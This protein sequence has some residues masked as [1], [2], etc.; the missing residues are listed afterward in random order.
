MTSPAFLVKQN[1]FVQELRSSYSLVL[2]IP[3]ENSLD[4]KARSLELKVS[5]VDAR[6]NE[7]HFK[8]V[9]ETVGSRASRDGARVFVGTASGA[10][11]DVFELTSTLS[12]RKIRE[13]VSFKAKDKSQSQPFSFAKVEI[14][15]A[16]GTPLWSNGIKIEAEKPVSSSGKNERNKPVS[17]NASKKPD[18]QKTVP[19]QVEETTRHQKVRKEEQPSEKRDV[20]K[21]AAEKSK[22]AKKPE[23]KKEVPASS[24][25]ST[26]AAKK[27]VPKQV[28]EQ[29]LDRS[30]SY[31]KMT[32]AEMLQELRTKPAELLAERK[33]GHQGF[34]VFTSGQALSAED[35]KRLMAF[36]TLCRKLGEYEVFN[37]LAGNNLNYLDVFNEV[38]VNGK[39]DDATQQAV[40]LL[41]NLLVKYLESTGVRNG[42]EIGTLGGKKV[43]LRTERLANGKVGAQ[44]ITA[45]FRFMSEQEKARELQAKPEAKE[46]ASD[47]AKEIEAI[48]KMPLNAR[49]SA[50]LFS[51]A[52]PVRPP[53]Q[54][55]EAPVQNDIDRFNGHDLMTQ[56]DI[57]AHSEKSAIKGKRRL[58]TLFLT[59]R[60]PINSN[61]SINQNNIDLS[62]TLS[63]LNRRAE[64]E[65]HVVIDFGGK[66][67]KITVEG[68]TLKAVPIE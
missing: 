45:L 37:E 18:A 27:T 67:C 19:A 51:I 4:G 7:V 24:K 36:Q 62:A 50:N 20:P 2:S 30:E 61:G 48:S 33:T 34:Q 64:K 3:K 46:A 22:E 49:Q 9:S 44:T 14:Y 1:K 26:P 35:R 16:N 23:E 28:E 59:R 12:G 53:E 43:I 15:N 21:T 25:K 52:P 41:Q 8:L 63:E 38:K 6:K 10:D 65:K 29:E 66:K 40:R 55:T 54:K 47:I 56:L 60:S 31:K 42:Q 58:L 5:A 32:L 68:T 13:A 17:D 11:L 39:F 57:I